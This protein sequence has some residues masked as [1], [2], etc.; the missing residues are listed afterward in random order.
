MPL[1]KINHYAPHKIIILFKHFNYKAIDPVE[2]T[3][4]NDVISDVI[5]GDII[6]GRTL[7]A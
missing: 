7:V 4:E 2:R 6:V 1:Y 3:V 5:I